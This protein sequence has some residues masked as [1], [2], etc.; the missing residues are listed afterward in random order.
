MR[1]ALFASGTGSNV[2][3]IIEYFS[4]NPKVSIVSVY[5]NKQNAGALTYATNALSP[6]FSIKSSSDTF[7]Q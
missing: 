7:A 2:K 3:N 5:S 1:I 4:D 6:P